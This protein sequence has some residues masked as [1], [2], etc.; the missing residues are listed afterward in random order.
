MTEAITE[1]QN[2]ERLVEKLES[3]LNLAC[4]A[5]EKENYLEA[6]LQFRKALYYE[7][8]LREVANAKEYIDAAV[9]IYRS[10]EPAGCPA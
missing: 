3:Y 8:K 2:R 9:P 10:S 6:A 1:V 4:E 5:E 7:A